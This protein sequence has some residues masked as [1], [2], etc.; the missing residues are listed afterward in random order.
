MRFIMRVINSSGKS[1]HHPLNPA[2]CHLATW[3]PDIPPSQKSKYKD[4]STDWEMPPVPATFL[5][6][7]VK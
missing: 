5:T 7:G 1:T 6:Y 3:L 4:K 2:L